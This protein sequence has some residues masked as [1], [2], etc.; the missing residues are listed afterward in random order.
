MI[1]TI[2]GPAGTGKTTVAKQVAQKLNIPYFDT[3]AMY[4]AAAYLVLQAN[5]PIDDENQIADLL[6]TFHFEIRYENEE[7]HY[8]VNGIDVTSAIRSEEISHTASSV[9]ALAQVREKLWP[10]QRTFAL[11]QGG[12][13]E[14][15]DMGT[16]VFPDAE[17]KI[18]LTAQEEIRAKRR[19]QELTNKNPNR[20]P[21]IDYFQILDQLK[22]RDQRDSSR[23]VA[24]LICPPDAYSIDTSFLTID[25]VVEKILKY[26][27]NKTGL[28]IKKI[29]NK[30]NLFY[31][32]VLA[33]SRF[34]IKGFYQLK[35]YGQE[36]YY[37]E[38][39]ILAANHV[40][41][42][43]PPIIAVSWPEE[44]HFL[45][46]FSL[47]Q[48]RLFGAILKRLNSHPINANGGNMGAIKTVCNLLL[49]GK[50]VVLFPEGTRSSNGE[51][52]PL[53]AG[54]AMILSQTEKAAIPIYIDGAYSVWNKKQKLP[55][56]RGK[57]S[58]VLGTP[59][60]WERFKHLE[61]K[62]AQQALT[63]QI[64][65]AI[66]HLKKWLEDGAKGIPP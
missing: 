62:A 25:Q 64:S 51:L 32:C 7:K 5:I 66:I 12:V 46:R 6:K 42:L 61:K 18:F 29:A 2:D 60:P 38:G 15:R 19:F 4:R 13:F 28:K 23:L 11:N 47:F 22:K 30:K 45:A 14:G 33:L 65:S 58:C 1:I 49:E 16:V 55:K 17:C 43:D 10:I 57:I 52:Q 39:A 54:I 24:P 41:F 27:K 44:I 20:T 26:Q 48:N 3:G 35:I 37:P 36:H 9:S 63:E 31:Q 8:W 53:K 59:I 50:K 21:S 34:W 56:L 40:S